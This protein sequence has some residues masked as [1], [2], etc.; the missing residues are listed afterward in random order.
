MCFSVN[1]NSKKIKITLF[2]HFLLKQTK[3]ST[4]K[5]NIK[6]VT[7]I[8]CVPCWRYPATSQEFWN[9]AQRQSVWSLTWWK[10]VFFCLRF[11]REILNIFAMLLCCSVSGHN[12][13]NV[14]IHKVFFLGYWC[15][16]EQETVSHPECEWFESQA[17]SLSFNGNTEFKPR[18][19]RRLQTCKP[20]YRGKTF[21]TTTNKTAINRPIDHTGET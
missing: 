18:F 1:A 4:A 7:C 10:T 19:C 6:S 2:R 9:L 17:I 8:T 3:T 14:I 21:Y 5:Y 13:N 20:L 16:R 11:H 15:Q 12:N